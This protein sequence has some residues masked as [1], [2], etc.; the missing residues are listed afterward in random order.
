MIIHKNVYNVTSWIE[1][2]PGGDAILKGAGKDATELFE[3]RSHSGYAHEKLGEF[4]V[5]RVK[6][7]ARYQLDY[8][9]DSEY[10]R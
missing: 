6:E 3:G 4:M 8:D 1:S 5:G 9:L 2:H 7:R 10:D